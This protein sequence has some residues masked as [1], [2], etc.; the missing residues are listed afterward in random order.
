MEPWK[1]K[2]R[3]G[4]CHSVAARAGACRPGPA[5]EAA[6]PPRQLDPFVRPPALRDRAVALRRD[7][8]PRVERD[9]R[10]VS[11]KLFGPEPS[12]SRPPPVW[13]TTDDPDTLRRLALEATEAD[14][15]RSD[16]ERAERQRWSE[17]L[18]AQERARASGRG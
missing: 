2:L 3:S 14:Q 17:E 5:C 13:M 6:T 18:A 11:G 7:G 15:A 9:G 16:G 8:L 10:D 4:R 1:A 12:A